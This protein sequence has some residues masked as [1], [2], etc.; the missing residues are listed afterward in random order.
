MA[1]KPVGEVVEV[2]AVLDALSSPTSSDVYE[3]L[4]P[5]SNDAV[6]A[7]AAKRALA[8]G[9]GGS[10]GGIRIV[11]Q[12]IGFADLVPFPTTRARGPFLDVAAGDLLVGFGFVIAEDFDDSGGSRMSVQVTGESSAESLSRVGFLPVQSF[13]ET[14]DTGEATGFRGRG[15]QSQSL[16]RGSGASPNVL[17]K[18]DETSTS[19]SI[20]SHLPTF[21]I[22]FSTAAQIALFSIDNWAFD[23]NAGLLRLYYY[24]CTPEAS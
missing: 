10:Q 1:D 9:G 12:E 17:S 3:A 13:A 18:P 7:V 22:E 5:Y 23:G 15:E 2:D 19:G 8:G 16:Y 6:A 14:W 4:Q 20:P 24:L 21:P 11:K